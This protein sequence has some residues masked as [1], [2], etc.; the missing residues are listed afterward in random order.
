MSEL[1]LSIKLRDRTMKSSPCSQKPISELFGMFFA[2]KTSVAK[3][4]S[5]FV[6]SKQKCIFAAE[7]II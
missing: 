4:C 6:N 5:F 2:L 7:K 3:N 1:S